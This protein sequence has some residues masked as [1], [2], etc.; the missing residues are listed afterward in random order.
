MAAT[1][2]KGPITRHRAGRGSSGRSSAGKRLLLIGALVVGIVVVAVIV[3]SAGGG[4]SPKHGATPTTTVTHVAGGH[5]SHGSKGSSG[6]ASLSAAAKAAMTVT[7]LNGTETE[8]L[9]HRTAAELQRDGYSQATPLGG[10]PSGANQASVV[11]YAPGQRTDAEEVARALSKSTVQPLEESVSALADSAQVVV[12]MG[13]DSGA[14]G[15]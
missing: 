9:A 8:G 13:A 10:K 6:H 5:H 4:S 1:G 2:E 11:E 3:T 14:T 15:Q 12:I 7:V